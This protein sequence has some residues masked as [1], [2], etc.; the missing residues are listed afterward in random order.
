M[1]SFIVLGHYT[2]K[3][4]EAIKDAPTRLDAVKQTARD[5]KVEMKAFYLTMGQ[6][7]CVFIM[8]A[9]NEEA[10]ARLMI[11]TS[12]RGYIRTET[13]RAFTEEEYRKIMGSLP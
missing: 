9:P 2:H 4:I 13:L 5:L 1:P 8:D 12:A 10:I 7:D 6:Y 11:S 3:G